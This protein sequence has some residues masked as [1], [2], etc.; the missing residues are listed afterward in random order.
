M[1]LRYR[2]NFEQA[3]NPSMASAH[4]QNGWLTY[5]SWHKNKLQSFVSSDSTIIVC[6]KTVESDIE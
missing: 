3:E 6:L 1:V 2:G 4:L 5:F